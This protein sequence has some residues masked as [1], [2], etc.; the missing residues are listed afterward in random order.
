MSIQGNM[1]MRGTDGVTVDYAK[2]R[3]LLERAERLGS[4]SAMT[5]LG[6]YPL[7]YFSLTLTEAE[8]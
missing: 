7:L 2:A 3:F 5:N 1:Y 6:A 8:P 4:A